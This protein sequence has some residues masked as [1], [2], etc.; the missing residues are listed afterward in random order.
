MSQLTW[1]NVAAPD[2]T[3]AMQGFKMS[4]DMLDGA[5]SAGQGVVAD[6]KAGQSTA[7]DRQLQLNLDRYND[8]D[9]LAAAKADGSVF[10]GVNTNK[11][12]PDQI[13]SVSGRA[14]TLLGQKTTSL[15]NADKSTANALSTITRGIQGSDAVNEVTARPYQQALIQIAHDPSLNWDDRNAAIS[16]YYKDNPDAKAAL[17]K[18]PYSAQLNTAQDIQNLVRNGLGNQGAQLGNTSA[19]LQIQNTVDGRQAAALAEQI[20]TKGTGPQTWDP[21][22]NDPDVVAKN[23]ANVR[24]LARQMLYADP[25]ATGSYVSSDGG[26]SGG[27]MG[28]GGAIGGGAIPGGDA[29]RVLN[30]VARGAGLGPSLPDSVK[31]MGDFSNWASQTNAKGVNSTAAGLYQIEGS[32]LRSVAPQVLGA[33]WQSKPFDAQNQDKVAERIYNTNN[34]SVAALR[35]QWPS[36][37]EAKAAQLVNGHVPWAQARGQIAPGESG[38]TE[39]MLNNYLQENATATGLKT[40][41]GQNATNPLQSAARSF[42]SLQGDTSTPAELASQLIAKGGPMEGEN[43]DATIKAIAAVRQRLGPNANDAQAAWALAHSLVGPKNPF[44]EALDKAGFALG[45]TNDGLHSKTDDAQLKSFEG[46]IKDPHALSAAAIA[47]GANQDAS[48]LVDQGKAMLQQARA[49]R[50]QHMMA[51]RL[52]GRPYNGA[53]DQAMIDYATSLMSGGTNVA[54]GIAASGNP[55]EAGNNAPAS[56]PARSA[57]VA[58]RGSRGPSIPQGA[59]NA[60]A[61][62]NRKI[63]EATQG[64]GPAQVPLLLQRLGQQWGAPVA[65]IR[66]N[67]MIAWKVAK[68]LDA[69]TASST[70]TPGI[71]DFRR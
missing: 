5:L 38:A 64:A 30:N 44:S 20:R 58:S 53:A 71:Q 28:G 14:G 8:P 39:A 4:N 37:T 55:P 42:V 34:S 26:Q 40:N 33:D 65:A 11:L 66:S 47:S 69:K 70:P 22:F 43:R 49:A 3:S 27:G 35:K 16:K 31:T 13:A 48:G 61:Y 32:T 50:M 15:E 36:L 68:M 60:Q 67:P 62:L 29:T 7:A 17:A 57:P 2:F 1:N 59:L 52:A 6:I 21:L 51:A 25:T 63:E 10:T 56:V 9:A 23:S 12:T 54:S 24:A 45:I 19:S 46:L 41:L 18:L